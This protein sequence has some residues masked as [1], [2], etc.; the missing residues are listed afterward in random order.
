LIKDYDLEVHY[1]LAN[2]NVVVVALSRKVSSHYLA[3]QLLEFTLCQELEKLNVEII[4]HGT[5][6]HL[7]HEST[8]IN[9][10]VEALKSN[11]LILRSKL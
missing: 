11:K 7:Q 9:Q 5:V 2:A 4:Q 1:H 3:T 10:I 6:A 8:L